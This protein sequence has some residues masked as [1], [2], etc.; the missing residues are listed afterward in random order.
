MNSVPT[1]R[2]LPSYTLIATATLGL[3]LFASLANAQSTDGTFTPAGNTGTVDWG[4]P[5]NWQGEIIAEGDGA[6]ANIHTEFTGGNRTITITGADRTLG[7]L[8]VL[9]NRTASSTSTTRAYTFTSADS[10]GFIFN[11][12]GSNAVINTAVFPSSGILSGSL[13]FNV[14]VEL[15]STLEINNNTV[16]SGSFNPVV[17][18]NGTVSGTGGLIIN[19]GAAQIGTAGANTNSYSGGTTINAGATLTIAGNNNGGSKDALGATSGVVT[20]NGG[21]LRNNTTSANTVYFDDGRQ[22]VLGSEGGT[23]EANSFM[24][25]GT[26]GATGASGSISGE[27]ALTKTGTN[28]LAFYENTVNT[29]T[30][31]TIIREGTLRIRTDANLGAATGAVTLD[32]GTLFNTTSIQFDAARDLIVGANGGT[33][34]TGQF[35]NWN[36]RFHGTGL[37]TKTGS[38]TLSLNRDDNTH[39]G[40][41]VVDAGTLRIR[42]GD[43]SLGAINNSLTLNDGATFSIHNNSSSTRTTLNNQRV[44]TLDGGMANILT[45]TAAT[46]HSSIVGSGGFVKQGDSELELTEANVYQGNTEVEAGT[47]LVNNTSGSGTGAGDVIVR[48]GA[49]LGGGGSIYGFTTLESGSFLD[50]NGNLRFDNDLTLGGTA[51]FDIDG[52]SRGVNYDAVN[53]GGLLTYGGDFEIIFTSALTGDYTYNLFQFLN[54]YSGSFNSVALSGLYTASLVNDGSGIWNGMSE[55]GISFVFDQSLGTLDVFVP[56]PST[57]ALLLGGAAAGFALIARRRKQQRA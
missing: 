55:S 44:I 23:I 11:N 21:T 40:G 22:I 41:I 48:S 53:V 24:H 18:F 1:P 26:P 15:Q 34:E 50:V 14:P 10:S 46:I 36:G 39:S 13:T 33:F 38:N 3:S 51:R 16:P 28:M 25:L 19:Q 9:Y 43:G 31:G 30:G 52:Q 6:T 4:T 32:G 27:G 8:N 20:L 35:A 29:H 5:G 54:G 17:S 47:L 2:L 56:E 45:Q 57:I 37:L 49:T 42:G 12:N 7:V